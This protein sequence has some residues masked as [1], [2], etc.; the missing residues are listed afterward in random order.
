MRRQE[1]DWWEKARVDAV[2]NNT[3]V[4]EE[5]NYNT[6]G[7]CYCGIRLQS[8]QTKQNSML[9]VS[10]VNGLRYKLMNKTRPICFVAKLFLQPN[11]M[12][13]HLYA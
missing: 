1:E 12:S 4:W 7:I 11:A 9:Y 5:S 10:S 13:I 8:S 3:G 2:S 6:A